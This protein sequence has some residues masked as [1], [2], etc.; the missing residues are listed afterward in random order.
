MRVK[1]AK[2]MKQVEA[3]AGPDGHMQTHA[4]TPSSIC[5]LGGAIIRSFT[6]RQRETER[7]RESV[8][9]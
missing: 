3:T 7:E 4:R 6:Q 5:L 2:P 1:L 8:T 9:H